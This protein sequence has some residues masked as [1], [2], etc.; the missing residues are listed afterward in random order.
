MKNKTCPFFGY[1]SGIDQKYIQG[2][3]KK[4]FEAVCVIISQFL[5]YMVEFF[6]SHY[7]HANKLLNY[8]YLY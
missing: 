4:L 1:S 7:S 6:P 8:I 5:L 3:L 2:A